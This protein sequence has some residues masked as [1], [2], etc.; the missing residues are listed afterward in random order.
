MRAHN[1]LA[2]S[3]SSQKKKKRRDSEKIL[4][5]ISSFGWIWNQG[6][7]DLGNCSSQDLISP[8]VSEKR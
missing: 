6:S 4:N 7:T 2:H 1:L 3:M 8:K 5:T